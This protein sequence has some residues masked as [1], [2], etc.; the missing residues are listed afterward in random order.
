[1]TE[2]AKCSP[3]GERRLPSRVGRFE[4]RKVLGK[5]TQGIVLLGHDEE[6]ERPV[7]IKLLRPGTVTTDTAQL[8]EEARMVAR[9]GRKS[10]AA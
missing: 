9:A 6:L 3:G 4:L 7:A 10:A 8:I 2:G 1:M 5:G